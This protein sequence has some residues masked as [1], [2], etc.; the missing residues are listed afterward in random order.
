MWQFLPFSIRTL[1][2]EQRRRGKVGCFRVNTYDRCVCV[3][4]CVKRKREKNQRTPGNSS[5]TLARASSDTS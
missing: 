2:V 3:C 1:R 4:V 5:S